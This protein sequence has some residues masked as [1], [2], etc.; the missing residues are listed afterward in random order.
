MLL[1]EVEQRG[2]ILKRRA[3]CLADHQ[4]ADQSGHSLESRIKHR[5]MRL[6]LGYED[7]ND[8]DTLRHDPLLAL[9]SDKQNLSGKTR[10]REQAKRCALAAKRTLNR[11]A[12]TPL[13]AGV[14][15]RYKKMVADPEGIDDPLGE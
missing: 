7:L 5:L 8:H 1:R 6:A 15:S 12:L 3:G 2:D 13:D 4:H 11:L 10:K 9:L 14:A